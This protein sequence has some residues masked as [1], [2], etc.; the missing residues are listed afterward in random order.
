MA[1]VPLAEDLLK[2]KLM[3]LEE[4]VVDRLAQRYQVARIWKIFHDLKVQVGP[5][6]IQKAGVDGFSVKMS[7][8]CET[9]VGLDVVF[10]RNQSMDVDKIKMVVTDDRG[11][12]LTPDLNRLLLEDR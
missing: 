7:T 4:Q 9:R 3:K 5:V 8:F 12:I 10:S 1:V 11:A 6:E 2:E